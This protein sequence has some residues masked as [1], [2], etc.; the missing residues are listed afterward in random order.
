MVQVLVDNQTN[1]TVVPRVSL[2]QVQIYMCARYGHKTQELELSERPV[3]G[4][5]IPAHTLVEQSLGLPLSEH[6]SLSFRCSL[7]AVKYYVRVT[8]DIPHSFDLHLN[9]PIVLTSKAVLEELEQEKNNSITP[10]EVKIAQ[11]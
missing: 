1:A 3:K 10:N 9:L 4:T 11:R 6:E 5:A 7:I 8:L 2:H